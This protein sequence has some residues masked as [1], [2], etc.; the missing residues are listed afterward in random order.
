M[1]MKEILDEI[2]GKVLINSKG[3]K[4]A[5]TE[6]TD[7]LKY[8]KELTEIIFLYIDQI[9]THN[10]E[11]GEMNLLWK[12]FETEHQGTYDINSLVASITKIMRHVHKDDD[13]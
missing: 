9:V 11:H 5:P 10:E 13:G 1:N 12:P 6:Y 8:D 4:D 2:N 3:K 7:G